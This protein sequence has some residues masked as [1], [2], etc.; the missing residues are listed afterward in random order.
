MCTRDVTLVYVVCEG[1]DAA[2]T[3]ELENVRYDGVLAYKHVTV[4]IF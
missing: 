1:D 2:T 3:N 4:L